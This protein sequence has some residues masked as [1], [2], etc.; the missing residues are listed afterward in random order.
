[1]TLETLK[2]LKRVGGHTVIVMDDL[3]TDHPE[4]FPNDSAQ[5]DYAIFEKDI[6]PNYPIQ[7]SHDKNSIAFTIQNGAIKE[8]GVNGCQVIDMIY[9]A[10]HII[11]NLNDKFPCDENQK[12]LDA[13]E[14]ALHWQAERTR[15]RVKRSVEGYDKA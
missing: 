10:K 15:D 6:R 2:D 5:M 4:L 7:I 14:D 12:T 3:K 13:L 8:N 9:V 11:S 1:M